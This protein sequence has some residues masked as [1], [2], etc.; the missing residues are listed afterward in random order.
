MEVKNW[1]SSRATK[2]K[3][4][5]F[6]SKLILQ[7]RPFGVISV[8]GSVNISLLISFLLGV[9]IRLPWYCTTVETLRQNFPGPSW[10]FNLL[11]WRK[12][13][14]YQL[15]T[16]VITI[17]DGAVRDFKKQFW[18]NKSWIRC[19]CLNPDPQKQLSH[20]ILQTDTTYITFVGRLSASKDP[21]TPIK[22]LDRLQSDYPGLKLYILGDGPLKPDLTA[23]AAENSLTGQINFLGSLTHPQV[24]Q[25]LAG[26][27]ANLCTSFTE[28]FGKVN[29]QALGMGVPIVVTR[30]E[31]IKDI[32]REG[33][34]GYGIEPG[35]DETAASHINYLLANPEHQQTLARQARKDFE[36]RFMLENN[37]ADQAQKLS[38][39]LSS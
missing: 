36:E 3:D 8:Y 11:K 30:V 16:G 39:F 22:A 31:G 28:A 29:T 26:S 32:L 23:F 35:D 10:K 19:L 4:A 15:A 34:N 13:M 2:L 20:P 25:V 5:L 24:Y 18:P 37:V 21:Y 38:D 27:V 1:P 12:K 7:Y 17:A 9:P 6:L 14:I 33:Y